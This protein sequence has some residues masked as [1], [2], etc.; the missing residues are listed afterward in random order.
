MKILSNLITFTAILFV[1]ST[2]QA[3]Y[4]DVIN[5]NRPGASQSA[6]SVGTKVLQF[7]VGPY[8][9]KEKRALYPEYEVDGYGVDFAAHYG[10]WKE[11]LELNIQ[12]TFQNDTQTF[13]SL[14]TVENKRS[15]FKSL[16]FGAK[17]LVYDPY[18]NKD[19]QPNVYSYHANRGFKWSSLIP[20]VSVAAGVNY[21]TPDN[22]YTAAAVEGLS[23][24]GVLITQNNFSGG[25]VFITNFMLD[26]IGSDQ[27]DFQY[28]LT[29]THSFDPKWVVFG[30]TQGIS[31]DFYADNLFRIGGGYLLSKDLQLDTALTLNTKDTP[32]VMRISFGASYRF[33]RH[34]DKE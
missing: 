3:Q 5:S 7:E 16:N 19:D 12:G 20:A 23:Y 32:S 24:R 13:S 31:S 21:D 10:F 4:T 25:W 18:K 14:T 22:P 26:R 11:A 6:F 28:I 27:T 34:K 15:N 29:L 8:M 17:Y 9:I 1:S 30:E 33:D 2:V